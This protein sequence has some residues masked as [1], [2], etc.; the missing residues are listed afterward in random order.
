MMPTHRN[1][2]ANQRVN[3]YLLLAEE[4]LSSLTVTALKDALRKECLSVAGKKA[5]LNEQ[6][7]QHMHTNPNTQDEMSPTDTGSWPSDSWHH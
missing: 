2:H 1:S 5:D 3:P 7:R 4:K 6:L